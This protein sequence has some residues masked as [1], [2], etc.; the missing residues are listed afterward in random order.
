MHRFRLPAIVG[1]CLVLSVGGF[2]CGSDRSARDV[3][4]RDRPTNIVSNADIRRT[5]PATPER[6]VLTWA[7]AVQFS[8]LAAV[9]ASYT[10]RVRRAVTPARLRDAAKVVSSVLGR[11]EIVNVSVE[12]RDARVRVALVSYTGDGR[13]AQQPATLALHLEDGRWRLDDAALLLDT[14]AAMRRAHG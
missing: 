6:T 12:G 7:Q 5:K 1:G 8:D 10:D 3:T 9:D 2:A 4:S 11:P 14:A 13:R